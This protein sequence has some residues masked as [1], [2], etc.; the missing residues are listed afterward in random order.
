[1][2]E[3][4]NRVTKAMPEDVYNQVISHLDSIEKAL[5]PY[6]VGTSADERMG[7]PKINVDNK[8]FVTDTITEMQ[9]PTAKNI[10]PG[11]FDPSTANEDIKMF[12]QCEVLTSRCSTLAD[13]LNGTRM[14]A[15]SE[16]YST[17]LTFKKLAETAETAGIPRALDIARKLR[18]RFKAQG[19]TTTPTPPIDGE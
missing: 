1:M 3:N 4:N 19:P 8:V 18:E 9:Q 15:G 6:I 7:L 16:A 11:Y 10:M 13:K 2:N 5:A 14:V 12:D 17:A